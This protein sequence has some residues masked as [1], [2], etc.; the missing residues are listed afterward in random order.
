MKIKHMIYRGS[1]PK[2]KYKHG[3]KLLGGT[4]I[5]RSWV[6][7]YWEYKI[8]HETVGTLYHNES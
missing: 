6:N 4:V 3:Q 1:I 5:G 2:P 8:I 7:T